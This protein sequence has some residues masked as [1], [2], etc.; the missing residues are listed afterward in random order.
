M[1]VQALFAFDRVKALAPQHPEWQTQEPF[2]S[3]LKGD[4]KGALAG[5]DKALLEI[6]MATHA[7]M[8]TDEFQQIVKDWISTAKQP[9][10]KA[11]CASRWPT[12]R[13]SSC[14]RTCV[15]T[16]TRRSSCPVAASSSCVR[17]PIIVY[18][19]PPEQVIG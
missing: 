9:G 14:W 13:W 7:G 3:V 11:P 4:V 5:G 19:I 18:G 17:G 10:D 16:A 15:H 1:Y 6:V 12:S 2:A 8:T